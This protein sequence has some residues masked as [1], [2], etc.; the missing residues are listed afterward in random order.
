[1][2]TMISSKRRKQYVQLERSK[3]YH[4]RQNENGMNYEIVLQSEAIGDIQS[5]FDWYE[6]QRSVLGHEFMNEIE[7]GLERL[8]RH[9]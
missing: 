2:K 5:V 6:H 8:S 7:E 9:P 3:R 4:Y 1:M